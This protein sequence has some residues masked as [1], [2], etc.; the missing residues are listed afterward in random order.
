MNVVKTIKILI[1]VLLNYQLQKKLT[2]VKVSK[3]KNKKRNL[4][5]I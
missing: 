2:K 1:P 4:T 5:Q 3:T